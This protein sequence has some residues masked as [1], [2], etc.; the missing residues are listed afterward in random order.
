MVRRTKRSDV[1]GPTPS[2]E[3]E[4]QRHLQ[5]NLFHTAFL[6]GHDVERAAASR[7]SPFASAA[8]W[9]AR[10]GDASLLWQAR[11][12]T[13]DAAGR[14]GQSAELATVAQQALAWAEAAGDQLVA[15]RAQR[16]LS[17][18]Y[19]VTG[20][21][22][23]AL[24]HA[25]AGVERLPVEAPAWMHGDHR[26]RLGIAHLSL[27]S[28][29]EAR[30]HFASLLADADASGDANLRLR[31]LNN[32]AAVE[33][34]A[35]RAREA[36]ELTDEVLQH[37][38]RTGVR[39]S[40]AAWDT[41][42]NARMLA[43]CWKSAAK[44][45]SAALSDARRITEARDIAHLHVSLATCQRQLGLLEQADQ[46][47]QVA[48]QHCEDRN[49]GEVRLELAEE[50]AALAAAT[51]DFATAYRV[52]Q[53]F[54]ALTMQRLSIRR[55]ARAR[56]LAAMLD[57]AEIQRL[58][59]HYRRLAERDH[60]TGLFNRRYLEQAAPAVLAAAE[61]SGRSCAVV[62]LDIDHFKAINDTYSHEVGDVVLQTFARI[63][64]EACPRGGLAARLGGEEFALL[65]PGGD[66][67]DARYRVDA[68]LQRIREYD[69]S[70]VGQEL[71]V[72]AS[73]GLVTT[74]AECSTL[75]ESLA[76]ADRLL[77]LAKGAG[78]DRLAA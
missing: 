9:Q 77:Y 45:L 59:E 15:A 20:D 17:T 36:V 60:L 2:S 32:L 49:L 6:V 24:E 50:T 23:L 73:A 56:V 22:A 12:I 74:G 8:A 76:A 55:D 62:L 4:V 5:D 1:V 68:L 14:G 21:G 44:I 39:L 53:D 11:L 42:A 69:W 72:T 18:L 78:R 30:R 34:T 33:V 54:H 35:G 25:V 46:S 57:T 3:T 40:A 52:Y 38:E 65:L 28:Y 29:D 41:V 71:R 63:L 66:L 16:L 31:T 37:S 27:H 7:A 61:S 58:G 67:Q 70:V 19:D 13:A 75:G 64:S 43:G 48:R 10:S 26:T 47:L 51:G